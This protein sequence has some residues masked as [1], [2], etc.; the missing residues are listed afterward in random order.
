[1]VRIASI[2]SPIHV[3]SVAIS[4][5]M[6]PIVIVSMSQKRKQQQKSQK[7]HMKINRN[8]YES[9]IFMHRISATWNLIAIRKFSEIK[10]KKKNRENGMDT[11]SEENGESINVMHEIAIFDTI[12]TR[13]HTHSQIE[14]FW[15][16]KHLQ[17]LKRF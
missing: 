4:C 15:A 9:V 8:S 13:T 12:S 3:E 6:S 1:M 5:G 2:N 10:K 16:H 11:A 17:Q 14:L 7:G